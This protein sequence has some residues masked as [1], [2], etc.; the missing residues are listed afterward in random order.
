M[1]L[2]IGSSAP[3]FTVLDSAGQSIALANFAGQWLLLSFFR[4]GACALCNLRVHQLIERFPALQ[5]QGLAVVTV[6]ESPLASIKQ[7]V[8]RQHPPFPII[9][10]PEAKLYDLYGVESSEE[11]VNTTMQRAETPAVI[12][13]A[14]AAGF[15]L[16]LEEGSNF[17]R[18]PADFLIGPDSRLHSLHYAD[19]VYDHLDFAVL[20]QALSMTGTAL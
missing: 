9:A 7:S 17:I 1:R 6:F 5:Q 16:T 2:S 8:G 19:Y 3:D 20:E 10:D 14:A 13:A 18:M 4:N 15:A 11:K 12:G